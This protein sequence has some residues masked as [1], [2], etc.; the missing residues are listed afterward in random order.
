LFDV[1][2]KKARG[3]NIG[4]SRSFLQVEP[5]SP[6]KSVFSISVNETNAFLID[7]SDFVRQLFS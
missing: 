6:R 1:W 4:A 5:T 2:W 3:V 7:I